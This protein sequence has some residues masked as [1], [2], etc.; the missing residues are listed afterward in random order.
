MILI[1]NPIQAPSHE[2]DEKEIKTPPI[3]V[4]DRR[5]FVGFLGIREENRCLPSHLRPET[6]SVSETLCSLVF[7][8]P[9]DGQSPK[10]Q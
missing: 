7:R 2:F 4:V 3:D 1:S 9:D 10:T 5:I 8:I 6:D